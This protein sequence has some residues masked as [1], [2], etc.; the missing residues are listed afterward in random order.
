MIVFQIFALVVGI[1]CLVYIKR[2]HKA[3][4]WYRAGERRFY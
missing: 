1:A 2:G 4:V 3:P